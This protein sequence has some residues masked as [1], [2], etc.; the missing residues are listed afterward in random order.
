MTKMI[1]S[2][3]KRGNVEFDE[4]HDAVEPFAMMATKKNTRGY[5]PRDN[6]K[7]FLG[8]CSRK[9]YGMEALILNDFAYLWRKGTK[10]R[11]A[12]RYQISPTVKG[13][14]MQLDK[15]GEWPILADGLHI[16][17]RPP[18]KT[19]SMAFRRSAKY[20]AA[21]VN[22]N[23]ATAARRK[24]GLTRTHQKSDGVSLQAWREGRG[25]F[26]KK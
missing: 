26:T 4:V 17:L 10:K 5:I 20:K 25:Y 23:K 7:C 2:H 24:K 9:G 1:G 3:K 16:V 18:S 8:M 21:R 6:L 22:W 13:A 11:I 12:T 19:S 14:I 15:V